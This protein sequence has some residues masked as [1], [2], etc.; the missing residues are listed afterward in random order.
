MTE[1]TAASRTRQGLRDA[2]HESHIRLHGHPAFAPL[3]A[4]P[5]DIA[6]YIVLLRKLHDF[7]APAE[8]A[9]FASAARLLPELDDLPL[10]CKAHLL[11]DDLEALGQPAPLAA[12]SFPAPMS[13]AEL[14]GG[15]YVI[16]GNTLGGRDLGRRLAPALHAVGLAGEAGRRFF[17]AYEPRQGAMWRKFCDALEAVAAGFSAAEHR[18]MQAAAL[19]M[20]AALELLLAV[21]IDV[22]SDCRSTR[23]SSLGVI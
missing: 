13:R 19:A 16:E 17:L 3:M 11:A 18:A 4:N 1:P 20:F 6:G 14:L 5:P 10:R 21:G 12:R 8:A 23:T 7:H 9:L 15:L 2:T 22:K